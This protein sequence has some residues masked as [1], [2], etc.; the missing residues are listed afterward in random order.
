MITQLPLQFAREEWAKQVILDS[1]AIALEEIRSLGWRPD[2][3]E[4]GD[5]VLTSVEEAIKRAVATLETTR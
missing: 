3:P 4:W 2:G 1:A 5:C